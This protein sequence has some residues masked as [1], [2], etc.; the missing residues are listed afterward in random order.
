MLKPII[1]RNDTLKKE[2]RQPSD[3]VTAGALLS[4]QSKGH[5]QK[6]FFPCSVPLKA[7][8]TYDKIS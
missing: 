2:A 3:A 6:P 4:G 7:P 1:Q 5:K 8:S